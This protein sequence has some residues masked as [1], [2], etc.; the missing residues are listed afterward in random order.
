MSNNATIEIQFLNGNLC[1]D[2]DERLFQSKSL[3]SFLVHGI[4]E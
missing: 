3:V 1:R 4:S 2:Y